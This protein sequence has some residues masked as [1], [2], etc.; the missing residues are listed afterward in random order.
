MVK[1]KL[2]ILASLAFVTSSPVSADGLHSSLSFP[3]CTDME[4][5]SNFNQ[6]DEMEY[7]VLR[8]GKKIGSHTIKFK[9]TDQGLKIRARTKM[10]VKLLFV[11]LF[12][13]EYIS[14]ELWCGDQ[15]LSVHTRVN[16]NGDKLNTKLVHTDGGYTVTSPDGQNIL[17]SEFQSTNHWNVN[18]TKARQVF[19]TITGKL[20]DVSYQPARE[21]TLET[22]IGQKL[23]TEYE[24]TGDLNINSFYD[25]A[26]NWSGMA[27]NHKDGSPIEFRCVSCGL[28]N[29]LPTSVSS[30]Q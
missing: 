11:T 19:N 7:D 14:E 6:M 22:K 18:V 20:N 12:R 15:L 5:S 1:D 16:D 10:K 3:Q 25:S 4:L 30:A 24:V 17:T 23:V 21:I 8:K 26:G 13:Y 28:P 2:V 9:P 29:E 27:F